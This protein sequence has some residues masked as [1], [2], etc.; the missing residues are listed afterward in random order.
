MTYFNKKEKYGTYISIGIDCNQDATTINQLDDI[1]SLVHILIAVGFNE[2]LTIL[3][4]L[5][6]TLV[7]LGLTIDDNKRL[8]EELMGD[9]VKGHET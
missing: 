6:D 7:G 9:I 1:L 8:V 3:Q 2:D 4:L 5:L